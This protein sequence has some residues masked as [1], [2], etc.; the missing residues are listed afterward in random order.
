MIADMANIDGFA[1]MRRAKAIY[2]ITALRAA[3]S[4][5]NQPRRSPSGDARPAL[6]L[7]LKCGGPAEVASYEA[8]WG[9]KKLGNT[10]ARDVSMSFQDQLPPPRKANGPALPPV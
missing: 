6:A 10:T 9:S 7:L 1:E 5:I 2:G 8:F 3:A 4:L